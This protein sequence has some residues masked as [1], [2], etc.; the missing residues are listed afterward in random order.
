[1]KQYIQN[2]VIS[3]VQCLHSVSGGEQFIVAISSS[4][5]SFQGR[6]QWLKISRQIS[7]WL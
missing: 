2:N 6:Q 1:M 4:G 7:Q 3:N 5:E